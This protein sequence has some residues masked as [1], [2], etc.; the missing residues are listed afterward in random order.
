MERNQKCL[1][2]GEDMYTNYVKQPLSSVI[3]VEKVISLHYF[4]FTRDFTYDGEKHPF[5]EL[6]FIDKG[7]MEVIADNKVS[8]LKKDEMIFHKPNEFHSILCNG[9][10]APNV[11][12]LS[13]DCNMPLFT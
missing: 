3:T 11:I 5:W 8:L 9:K 6:V 2:S 13:F 4:E 10:I 12:I 7:E 1:L